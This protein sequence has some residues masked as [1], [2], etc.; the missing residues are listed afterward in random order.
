MAYKLF[1]ANEIL[2]AQDVNDFLMEQ[3]VMVFAND[4]ARNTAL[5]SVLTDGM[6]VY[7]QDV[8]QFQIRI[9]GT[10]Q[11]MGTYAEVQAESATDAKLELYMEVI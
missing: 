5:T 7:L 10:W 11:R 3:A 1:V 9:N 4:S 6:A 8:D 2:T